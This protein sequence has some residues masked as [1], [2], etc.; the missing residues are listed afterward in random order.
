MPSID[1]QL[2]I[3]KFGNH[4]QRVSDVVGRPIVQF[5]EYR[6]RLIADVVTGKLDIRHIAPP[7]DSL[8]ADDETAMD[9]DES[10]HEL[11]DDDDAELIE[12][13]DDAD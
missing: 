7:P 2:E 5:R 10:D 13:A 8:E 1:E 4:L 9:A 3:E 11:A 12:E 6:T